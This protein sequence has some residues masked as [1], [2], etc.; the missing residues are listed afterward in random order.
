MKDTENLTA[1]PEKVEYNIERSPYYVPAAFA[2]ML[3]GLI[4]LF[5][6]FLF[7]DNMLYGSDMLTAGIYHRSMLVEYFNA[8]GQIP[9]WDPHVFGGIPYVDAF[10]G[11]IFY[12]FSVLKFFIPLYFHLGFN[13]I[14]HIF[15]AG[16][17]MYLA[18]R[19]FKLGKTAALFSAASYMFAAYLVSMV[20]AGHE[21]RIYV[22]ALFPLV[23][24]FLDRGFE[25]KQFLNF[26]ILG[27]ILG[28]IIVSPHPQMAYFSLWAVGFY[29]LFKLIV[30]WRE[31]E[32]I[33]SII[34]PASLAAYAVVIALLLSAI[35]FYPGYIY[36]TEF[37]PRAIQRESESWSTSWSMHEEEVASLFIPEFSGT[38]FPRL[39]FV[40][41]KTEQS[42]YWGKNYFK[43]SSESAG[44]VPLF[45]ALFALV[46]VRRKEKYFFGGLA[47]FALIYALGATTPIF[48]I[49]YYLIPKVKSLRA[50]SMIMFIFSF[51]IALLGGMAVQ[52]IMDWRKSGNVAR[53]RKINYLL[54]GFPAL[55]FL[56]ALLFNIAGNEMLSAWNSLFYSD[57]ATTVVR[58]GVTKLDLAMLNLPAIQSGAWM[59]A[60]F[61]ALVA[62][63]TWLFLSGKA[64]VAI[65]SLLIVLPVIDGVRFNRRFVDVLDPLTYFGAKAYTVFLQAQPGQFRVLN[66]TRDVPKSILPQFGIEVVTG[67]H[68][69]QL[70]WYSAL[71]G[72]PKFENRSNRHFLNLVGAK[73][74]LIPA[75]AMIVDDYFGEIPTTTAAIIGNV[76]ILQNHNALERVY[77]V[78]DY[79]VFEDRRYIY[80]YILRGG[81]DLSQFVYLEKEPDI[82]MST[83]S[84]G[85]DS[86]WII[87]RAMDSVVV[88][89]NC[90]SNRLLVLTENYYDSWQVFV[91]G[92][93]AELLRSYGTFRAVAVPK[94]AKQVLFRYTSE[95]YATGKLITFVTSLYL[96]A[97]FGFYF[98]KDW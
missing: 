9:Q 93:P 14:L 70:R 83:D 30:L 98:R 2:L 38:S 97:V 10:H 84:L 16:V 95:R 3:L 50:P 5:S 26:S 40:S 71:M 94:G 86:A 51:S 53:R 36:T 80:P 91:D 62:L 19:Q 42:S 25:Q 74:V 22:T 54:F 34:K 39:P 63:I 49:F 82:K 8:H 59:A 44:V 11:D 57:I 43:D 75:N 13:L 37:S 69:N 76:K 12:P 45:L 27:L 21:G 68:G 35:Q 60:L 92:R 73:Y 81:D 24:L 32:K 47:L 23:M 77:L 15:F 61:T 20:A 31:N 18:A 58:Q 87:S 78:N 67:Y 72:G 17:F 41:R 48:K 1:V 79:Q 6:D 88:G 28:I 46:F 64:A 85:S 90:S 66:L 65:L 96:L 4:I 56:L 52:A 89:L 33:L 7:S 55:M 29:S